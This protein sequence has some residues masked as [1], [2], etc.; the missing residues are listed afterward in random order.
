MLFL[1]Q[2]IFCSQ[3]ILD[4]N[5]P[6]D[7][8]I[9]IS[10][11][12]RAYENKD[13]CE[14]VGMQQKSQEATKAVDKYL[15]V[16]QSDSNLLTYFTGKDLKSRCK[17]VDYDLCNFS[18]LITEENNLMPPSC[19]RSTVI[20]YVSKKHHCASEESRNDTKR[21]KASNI[22]ENHTM[23]HSQIGTSR[24]D[25]KNLLLHKNQNDL[26]Q[27]QYVTSENNA[28]LQKNNN[29]LVFSKNQN[30]Y[31]KTNGVNEL[32]D[33]QTDAL[34]NFDNVLLKNTS[35]GSYSLNNSY[36]NDNNEKDKGTKPKIIILSNIQTNG[37]D[38]TL[39][40]KR[41]IKTS[42]I[43]LKS[44]FTASERELYKKY[45]RS[46]KNFR[47][48]YKLDIKSRM[49]QFI[50]Q[51]E[52]SNLSHDLKQNSIFALRSLLSFLDTISAIYINT[53]KK[54]N[55]KDFINS[56]NPACNQFSKYADV[57]QKL[58]IFKLIC[59]NLHEVNDGGFCCISDCDFYEIYHL[60]FSVDI[61][62]NS[63]YKRL[64]KLRDNFK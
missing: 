49:P 44:Q 63:L 54:K 23:E 43:T 24:N 34:F 51:L 9:N 7:L 31:L 46:E 27:E 10:S 57:S 8:R 26:I 21:L 36:K 47:E 48:I 30:Y 1:F 28:F 32:N 50:N 61:R 6:L 13:F 5:E 35:K 22:L 40:S 53:K 58:L 62:F 37:N 38:F 33:V 64:A 45:Q 19:T 25:N 42:R 20:K 41:K 56:L 17:D 52:I 60:L 39:K 55:K 12:P 4:H 18:S 2:I 3:Q 59:N 15:D 11:T 29:V 14:N 16:N